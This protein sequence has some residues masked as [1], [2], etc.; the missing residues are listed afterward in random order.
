MKPTNESERLMEIER[1]RKR[2]GELE[3]Q[4]VWT[5]SIQDLQL[6]RANQQLTS[7]NQQLRVTEQSL[8]ENEAL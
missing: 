3:T 1:L 7:A 6:R 5:R 2:I 4:A 8:R